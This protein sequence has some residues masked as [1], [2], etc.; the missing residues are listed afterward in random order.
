MCLFGHDFRDDRRYHKKSGDYPLYVSDHLDA[1]WQNGHA[2][3]GELTFDS[4]AYV[5]RYCTEKITGV[6]AHKPD[7][8]TGLKHYEKVD[9]STGEIFELLPEYTTCSL[10]PAI[11]R[12]HYDKYRDNIY[13]Y[14]E[15]FAAGRLQKPPKYYDK[16]YEID[17][18]DHHA[19]IKNLRKK[20][21]ETCEHATAERLKAREEVK[22]AQLSLY[23]KKR[24]TDSYDQFE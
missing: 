15:I 2:Y 5:A 21:A 22:K 4:A 12:A 11:G 7:P 24:N 19:V 13:S 8:D 10:K 18:P 14:D 17:N 16:R 6:A 9:E 20:L 23:I 3:I 1:I